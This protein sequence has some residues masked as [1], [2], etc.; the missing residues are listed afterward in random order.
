MQPFVNLEGVFVIDLIFSL[1]Q[2]KNSIVSMI[3][4]VIHNGCRTSY[5]SSSLKIKL[6]FSKYFCRV[7]IFFF[8][9][10]L[11]GSKSL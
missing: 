2:H 8:E 11:V 6:G 7:E 5:L 4:K 1:F 3:P 9:V 10:L